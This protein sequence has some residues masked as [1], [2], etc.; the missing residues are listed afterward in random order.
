M[1]TAYISIG[2]SDDKL[3]Q[4]EWSHYVAELN[5]LIDKFATRVHGRW[6]SRPDD[7]WQN[8]CVCVEVEPEPFATLQGGLAGLRIGFRQD[9]IAVAI[10]GETRFI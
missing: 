6:F 10:V 1:I 7:P 3:T 9:S 5:H 2:N 8:H 4:A